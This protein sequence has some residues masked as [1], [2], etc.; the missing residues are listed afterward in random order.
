MECT[1]GLWA[2]SWQSE[3]VSQTDFSQNSPVLSASSDFFSMSTNAA[4]WSKSSLRFFCL[5]RDSSGLRRSTT[6]RVSSN[7]STK[8]PSIRSMQLLL[9]ASYMYLR[10]KQRKFY[11]N[12]KYSKQRSTYCARRTVNLK[13]WNIGCVY[14]LKISSTPWGY[15]FT[16]RICFLLKMLVLKLA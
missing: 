16:K 8:P 9:Q 13:V 6:Q 14:V 5:S 3:S 15:N 10:E 11:V 7:A 1:L 4:I 12:M 2:F